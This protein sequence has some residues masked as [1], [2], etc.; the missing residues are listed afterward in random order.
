MSGHLVKY[1]LVQI[2]N[3]YLHVIRLLVNI[4]FIGICSAIN[5]V[6]ITRSSSITVCASRLSILLLK[7]TEFLKIRK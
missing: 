6:F 4:G 2:T 7:I 5:Y 3:Y 1:C